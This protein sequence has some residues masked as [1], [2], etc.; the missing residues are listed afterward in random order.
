MKM[1]FTTVILFS[2]IV[3]ILAVCEPPCPTG[4]V[5]VGV[6]CLPQASIPTNQ[7]L[8]PPIS[9]TCI[10]HF[11]CPDCST[12]EN[13][14]SG[15][16][17][18]FPLPTTCKRNLVVTGAFM[19]WYSFNKTLP[20]SN[21]EIILDFN[22]KKM[23]FQSRVG[24]G[25]LSTVPGWTDSSRTLVEAAHDLHNIIDPESITSIIDP[26]WIIDPESYISMIVQSGNPIERE[27]GLQPSPFIILDN[28]NENLASLMPHGVDKV[29]R[30]PVLELIPTIASDYLIPSGGKLIA[31]IL[32][33]DGKTVISDPTLLEPN[34]SCG[35]PA[36]SQVSVA[37]IV[38][39]GTR[40]T[41]NHNEQMTT[42]QKERVKIFE[43]MISYSKYGIIVQ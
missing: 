32:F 25:V 23:K 10:N 41:L 13:G 11:K 2:L 24:T 8:C 14:W 1:M 40:I 4:M 26:T 42:E 15:A 19:R 18:D 17:C 21:V 38:Q 37:I 34:F 9:C 29:F 27:L 30:S 7:T 3:K 36:M 22:S 12:C 39:D 20:Y 5:C 33:P 31:S 16:K 35:A 43:V 6:S 28:V